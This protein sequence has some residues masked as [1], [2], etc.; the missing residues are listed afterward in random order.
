M[1]LVPWP[2]STAAVSRA[3]AVSVLVGAAGCT[4]A[5]AERLG[6]VAAALV[7]AYVG[8]ADVPQAVLDEALIRSVAWLKGVRPSSAV[9][10]I[11][12]GDLAITTDGRRV[13]SGALRGSGA[14]ALLAPW[15]V[16]DG[17]ICE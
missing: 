8:A 17:G 5:Q 14:A 3:A 16:N 4:S 1:A 10:S 12:V 2:G 11:R 7:I 9:S 15:H 13:R 6:P